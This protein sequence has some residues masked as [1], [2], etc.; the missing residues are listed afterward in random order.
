MDLIDSINGY[1]NF[2]PF[3]TKV[4]PLI[5]IF[6][7]NSN[8]YLNIQK[9]YIS[10]NI[11]QL[12]HYILPAKKYGGTERIIY[13]LSRALKKL[14]HTVYLIAP[15]GTVVD[16]VEVI[17]YKGKLKDNLQVIPANA[18]IVHIHYTPDF[19]IPKPFVVTI[20]GNKK[21]GEKFLPNTVF[22]SKNHA[23]RHNSDFYVYNGLDPEEYIYNEHKE[24]Y[25]LFLSKTSRREKGLD[26]AIRIA[27]KMNIN[28]KI[29]GGYGFSFRK[30]IKYYGEVG[31]RVKA[32]LIAGAKALLFPI[33]WEEPFGLVL[34][35]ALVSGTPVIATKMGAVPEIVTPDVGFLCD[36][37]DELVKAVENINSIKPAACRDRVMHHFTDVIMAKNYLKYYQIFKEKFLFY[38]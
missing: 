19:S 22:L 1:S 34:I 38:E 25:F 8:F 7:S 15:K 9:K 28:L 20:H 13:W 23:M 17:S 30:N 12:S 18:D 2:T 14:G 29:A 5:F 21:E 27:K 31:G 37:E 10:M 6:G 3:R 33:R 4:N 32:E 35:E 24:N 26:T 36:T 16:G 11:V